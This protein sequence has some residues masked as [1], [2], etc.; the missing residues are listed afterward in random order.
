V[1]LTGMGAGSLRIS[2]WRHHV[3]ALNIRAD[4]DHHEAA[5]TWTAHV[6]Y[7]ICHSFHEIKQLKIE[8][9]IP[10]PITDCLGIRPITLEN[11]F[12]RPISRISTHSNR[13]G[14]VMLAV[15]FL[16]C[17]ISLDSVGTLTC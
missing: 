11:K 7:T 15:D 3:R 6:R 10:I 13:A 9:S 1:P 8:R 5:K 2:L 12:I 16:T 14:G 4:P 17:Y